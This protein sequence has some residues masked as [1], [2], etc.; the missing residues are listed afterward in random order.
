MRS[1]R[2][3]LLVVALAGCGEAAS[4]DPPHTRYTIKVVAAPDTKDTFDAT[5]T[6]TRAGRWNCTVVHPR[7]FRCRNLT[8][9]QTDALDETGCP[10]KRRR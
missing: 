3:A 2:L 10:P 8:A 7:R 4:A 6:E 9:A 5:C 1:L